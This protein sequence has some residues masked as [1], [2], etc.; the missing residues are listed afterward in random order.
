MTFTHALFV[1][2]LCAAVGSYAWGMRGTIIGGERGALLP[3]A[4]LATVLIC[5]GGVEPVSEAF[6]FAAA[7]GA[8][9]MFFGGAQTYGET[10]GLTFDADK[11]TRMHGRLG[12]AIKGANWFGIFAGVLGVGLG[13]MAG[14]YALWEL[15]LFT[16]LLPAV[17]WLG[18]FGLKLLRKK[19]PQLYFSK[20]RFEVWG[21]MTLLWVYILLFAALHKE[22]FP[23]LLGVFGFVSGALGFWV[24]N[25]FQTKFDGKGNG[26]IGGWKWMEC[27]FGAIGGL[28]VALCWCLF[29]DIF[30]YK[31]AFQIVGH[32]GVWTLLREQTNAILLF[33]WLFLFVLFLLHYLFD[34]KKQDTSKAAKLAY[35][36]EDVLVW[37]VFCYVPLFLAMSGNARAAQIESFFMVLYVIGDKIIFGG[38]KHYENLFG[39][40]VYHCALMLLPAAVLY[41][42][43]FTDY[44]FSALQTML[45]YLLAYLL[46]EYYAVFNLNRMRP[47]C[48]EHGS[49][50]K[51]L[52]SMGST[53]SWM[54]YAGVCCIAITGMSVFYF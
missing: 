11:K 46:A 18:V 39:E 29:Y 30:V 22:W 13:A 7:I 51:A 23:V 38:A 44:T 54:V 4:A 43:L 41:V 26:F 27:A 32:S 34:P 24:G 21:G 52:L 48:A 49:A 31:Y 40:K 36:A 19:L 3:G 50:A 33:A 45:M 42:Q 2:L 8:A 28:G 12:L 17:K 20:T 53:L 10:I 15:L 5:A 37:P 25:L 6:P 14:R 1:M 35:R 16:L 47:L 9:A